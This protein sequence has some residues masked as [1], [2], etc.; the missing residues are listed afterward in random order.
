MIANDEGNAVALT[1]H[2]A[3][4]EEGELQAVPGSTAP[5]MIV[6]DNRTASTYEGL[7]DGVVAAGVVYKRAGGRI[8]IL[9]TSVFPQFRGRGI[10]AA[11]LAGVL[12]DVRA[13]GER[14]AVTCPFT[15]RFIA[16]HTEYSDLLDPDRPGVPRNQHP[17]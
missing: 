2:D 13:R 17:E 6:R 9:A 8:T 4:G 1:A 3:S 10:A 7:V 5:R 14:V 15:A 16:S 12:E 11:L